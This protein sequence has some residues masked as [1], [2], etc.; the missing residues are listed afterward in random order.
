[1]NMS[2]SKNIKHIC[3]G[4]L[5][6]VDAGKTTC[7]E[8]MLLN[9]GTIRKAGRVDHG[10][11]I[12]DYDEQE[13]S[14][15]IT[16]Y[17]KEAHMKWMD[18]EIDLIDTPGHVDFSAEMERSLSV[19]DMAV[20]LINGQD[21]VQAHTHT[22]WKCLAH[23]NVPCM[24]F[25]NKMDISYHTKEELLS[26]LHTHCS[27]MCVLWD[28]NRDDTLAMAND[29][30]LEAASQTGEIPEQ[31]LQQA[32]MKRQFFPVLFGS[33]LKN[34][35]VDTLMNLM[36]QL[37]PQ[38]EYP[39]TF[40]AKVFRISTDPQGNRLT[41]MRITGGVLHA[42]D[43]FSEE[44]KA[45]Q[46]RRY[47]GVKYDLLMEATGGEVVCIKGVSSLEAGAGLGFEKDSS[48]S[49]LNAS[50]TYQLE[51]LEGASPLVLADTCATLASEDPRLEIS[52]DERTGR[53]S[54]C[55]MGK[56]QMEV[57]Q[58]KIFESSGIMVGFSTGKI[59]YQETIKA[60]VEGAGHFEPLRHYAEVHVRLD[61]LPTGSGIQ[62]VSGIGT[63]S[64]SASWQRSI[65]SALSRKRHRG[66]LTGSFLTDVR[67]ILT[68]GKGH[69]KHTMGGDFRQAA[70]RAVRQALMKAESILLE[71]YE[72]FELTVPSESLS[73]ALFDLENRE[74]SIEVKENE[75]GTMCIQGEGPV[76]TLQNY[77]GE[78]TVYTKGKGIFLSET[79]GF[80]PCKEADR[81]IAEIGYDPE[82]DLHHPADSVFCANGSGYN[83]R[84]DEADEHMHIQL[85]NGEV[86]SSA[87]RSTRYKV[88]EGDLGYI[89]EMTA[90]RNRNPDKEAEE[91]IRKEKEKKREEMAEMSRVRASVNLPDMM[92]V[93]GYNMVYAW[94]ELK[95]LAQE[96]LYLAR[97]KLITALYNWQAYYGHPITVVFDGYRVANNTGTT[98][99]K[100]DLTIV[101][102]K[103][104]ET[105]DTWIERF[106]YQNQ[107]RYRITYVS[108]DA[109]IQ[110]AVLSRN[111]LRMS[112]NAL[113]Q[114]LKEFSIL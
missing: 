104:G 113:Y 20:L 54:V 15:G 80:R 58:K 44:D 73:R 27:D 76:R 3:T 24:I 98:L 13:R 86:P 40:G 4:L 19:L 43:R 6:H 47:N 37:V 17:A 36:C 97:E 67:I 2:E 87:M 83:V 60:P 64:L 69:I 94:D 29:E 75:N 30:I 62:V 21:G 8:A 91:R 49:L 89:M 103:T 108:S 84:W 85:K 77:N 11:T 12:L 96:D 39:E 46:I 100:Q 65:L 48:S 92:V 61:P 110:N 82:M 50:M 45:D 56:M 26:D 72:S 114:K 55:I 112:A 53:I 28:E 18:A 99:K 1:M 101:Y 31:L 68:A 106:S 22:I 109:L 32:F 7:V 14:H 23:Y 107:N 9:S 88:S 59:V 111:G 66:V 52:T 34:Q 105:A 78:V 5:A 33:A 93:D 51:L 42:R 95:S 57:L 16:I 70:G 71:P 10:D 63:D 41:H 74:C 79:A 102:T 90:G 35:G 25:V 38:R 81:I